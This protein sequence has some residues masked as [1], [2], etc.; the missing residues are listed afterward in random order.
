MR[1]GGKLLVECLEVLGARHGFGVPGES[2]LT[3]L[4]GLHQSPITFVNTRNEGGAGFMAAAYGKLTGSPGLCFVTRGPG[5]T[6]A[7][8][9]VHTAMQ[10]SA[11]M[12]L[13]VG[14]IETTTRDREVFQEVDYRA[15][16]G[17]IAK[18]VTEIEHV[19]RIPEIVS[20]AWATA[21]SGRPGPV[22]VAL[23]ENVVGAMTDVAA[24]TRAPS[25]PMPSAAPEALDQ[26]RHALSAC[27]RPLI[28]TGGGGWTSEGSLA[29]QNF[30]EASGIPVVTA[31]R[32]HDIYDNR[33]STFVGEAGV[34]MLPGVRETLMESDLILAI[35]VRF[36]EMT[37]DN[38]AT[39]VL[40][41]MEQTLIHVHQSSGEIGKIFLPDIAIQSNPN[42][43]ASALANAPL[44]NRWN[45]WLA[46]AQSRHAASFD[47]PEQPG[48]V[49]MVKVMAFLEDRLDDTAILT[50][51]AGNFSIWN[52]KYFRYG[53]GQR[54]LAPQSGA[55]GYG[56]PAAIMAKIVHPDRTVVCFAGDGDFQMNCQELGTA[57]QVGA[58]PIVLLLNNASYGT[59][60]MHQERHFPN[61]VSGTDL[62]NPD[63][64]ALARSYGMLGERIERTED[65]APAFERA[66]GSP[67]GAVLDIP[68]PTEAI[69]PNV[70]LAEIRA[71]AQ[72]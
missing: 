28:L 70:T 56:L 65:F 21:L 64:A 41:D 3:V 68:I 40:P 4:D 5:A 1:H 17:G 19:E 52:G 27:E 43:F 62:A 29:L 60:R 26:L 6:N 15:F 38:Y 9:G 51:G 8:I 36:G 55:M 25:L 32:Y 20:R 45:D 72:K 13:F 42:A 50:N 35:N 12:I 58:A 11:P 22:V 53:A 59:I 18:W 16:F 37:T 10:D 24:I 44:A 33:L 69:L 23:P 7:S 46:K 67:T 57:M 39:F 34:G 30:A 31:F 71:S 61:R 48:P 2:Y 49:N 63:F 47:L 54:L 66:L 14:Q